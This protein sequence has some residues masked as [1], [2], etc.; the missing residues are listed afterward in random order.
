MK[1]NDFGENAP[2]QLVE[3]TLPTG[4][5]YWA[6]VPNA[7]PPH[8]E[9]DRETVAILSEADQ[10]LGRLDGIGRTLLN[11]H[12]LIGPFLRCE[13]VASSRI[14]GTITD[15]R[16]FLL[17]EANPKD[18]EGSADSVEVANYIRALKYGL[19]SIRSR[20]ISLQLLCETHQR[21]MAGARGEDK[22]PGRFRERQNMIGRMGQRPT[23]ARFVPPPVLQMV[24][25]LRDLDAYIQGPRNL[26][27]LIDLALIHYQ[28]EAIHPF[29]DGNGRLGRV[30]V[31][32]LLG[33]RGCLSQPLLYLSSYLED[34]K[35][36]YM[37]HLLAVSRTGDWGPWIR[38]FLRGI[39]AQSRA[40]VDRCGELLDLR[41]DYR[42]DLLAAGNSANDLRLLDA[43][44]EG[45]STTIA[46]AAKLLEMT[47]PGARNC[48]QRLVSAG[49]LEEVTGK[50]RDRIYLAPAILE[51]IQRSEVAG[52]R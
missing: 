32:L 24:G 30:L 3:A 8:V 25:A 45:P 14:E 15:L 16:Q 7:L 1:R 27:T 44:F 10:A 37:D 9:F 47:V 19:D 33:E 18:D 2:G 21:L 42:K 4:E 29:L 22:M 12:M 50:S 40:A 41:E 38:F 20:P 31:S 13:A 43:L 11:P 46:R 35:D 5:R 36:T 28:F 39:A 34:H 52:G 51:I 49:V 26:P 23:E 48:V 6:F 17:Y